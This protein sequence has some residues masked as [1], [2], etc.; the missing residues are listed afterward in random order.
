MK[1]AKLTVIISVVLAVVLLA[2]TFIFRF[3]RDVESGW[4][5]LIR[6]DLNDDEFNTADVEKIL[7]QAGA[8]DVVVQKQITLKSNTEYKGGSRAVIY[9]YAE[10]PTEVF[11]EAEKLLSDKYVLKYDGV[12]YELSGTITYASLLNLWPLLIVLAAVLAYIFI[13]FG[14]SS[15]I[16]ALVSTFVALCVSAG[17]VSVTG[18][19]VGTY[20]VPAFIAAAASILMFNIVF[21]LIN[22]ENAKRISGQAAAFAES[23]KQMKVITVVLSAAA[24][25]ALALVLILGNAILKN[26][27]VTFIIVTAVNA[28]AALLLMP[29]LAGFSVKEK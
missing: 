29:A 25:A 9:F 8:G 11:K 26:F 27:A 12:L 18:T 1:N 14:A 3:T 5:N 24:I 19:R 23:V 28:V 10:N 13:R 6:V 22:K 7:K 15:G 4:A 16:T 20:S 2:C 21:N 17:I